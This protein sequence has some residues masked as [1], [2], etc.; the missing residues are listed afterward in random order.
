VGG[1]GGFVLCEWHVQA[2]SHDEKV[3]PRSPLE[4][5]FR[6]QALALVIPIIRL[7]ECGK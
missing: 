4:R 6:S 3:R 7:S 5:H 1:E 2:R